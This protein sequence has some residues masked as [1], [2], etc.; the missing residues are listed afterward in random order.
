MQPSLMRF[1]LAMALSLP[2]LSATAGLMEGEVEGE[3]FSI[4]VTCSDPDARSFDASTPDMGMILTGGL[5]WSYWARD[6]HRRIRV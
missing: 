4:P 6:Y 3:V 1:S 2:A 5:S